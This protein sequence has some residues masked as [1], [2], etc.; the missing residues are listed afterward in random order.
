MGGVRVLLVGRPVA[1]VGAQHDQ[2]GLVGDRAG[3]VDRRL[4]V[5]ELHVLAQVLHV[6]AVRLEALAHVL[7]E[8]HPGLAGELDVVVVVEGGQLA[9]AEVAGER[10]GL[11]G[12]ALLD[13]AVAGDREGAVVDQVVPGAVVT[14][15]QHRLGEREAD[16]HRDALA[17]RAGGGLDP[18]RV[19]ALGVP[20]GRAAQLAEVLQV[21][22]RQPVAGQVERRVEQ[23]RGVAGREHE[24]VAVEPV[25]VGRV[26]LHDA[27]VEQIRERGERHGRA[28][29]PR[30]R[31][32]HGVHRQG[33]DRVDGE[34]V[35]LRAAG[36]H[37][38]PSVVVA[39]RD[40]LSR[41]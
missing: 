8:G 28:G 25:R 31:L 2:R 35:Q 17:E 18:G 32:L 19:A 24:A 10:A 22:E 36:R 20:G 30:L 1:D 14:G 39:C 23:H 5:V 3:G 6:P 27:R 15:G 41:F 33:A 13:V 34:L 12:H 38:A 16:R 4:D 21:V 40:G 29:M 9:E 11:G 7:R 26:V 37:S